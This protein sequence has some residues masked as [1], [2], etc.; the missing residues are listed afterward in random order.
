MQ[1]LQPQFIFSP[2]GTGLEVTPLVVDGVMYVTGGGA[3][4]CHQRTHRQFHMVHAAHQW[5]RIRSVRRS[6]NPSK[7]SQG[8]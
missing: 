6:E 4:L 2:G 7:S 3:N 8:A 1:Q 5:A